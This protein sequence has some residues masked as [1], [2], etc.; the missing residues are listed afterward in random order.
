MQACLNQEKNLVLY[1][2]GELDAVTGKKIANHLAGCEPCRSEY[3]QL[4]SLLGNIRETVATPVLSSKQVNS[5]VA[6]IKWRL[7]SGEKEKW[8]RRYAD[9]APSR[10][11]PAVAAACILIIVAGIIGYQILD[12]APQLPQLAGRQSEDLMLS[13]HDLEIVKNLEFLKDMDAIRKLAQVVDAN[14]KADSPEKPDVDTRGMRW[15]GYHK[16]FA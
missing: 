2:H 3:R 6:N 8:W 13:D 4:V 12:R 16:Y 10:I 15:D 5:M 9:F 1:A 14:G 11:V 7:K